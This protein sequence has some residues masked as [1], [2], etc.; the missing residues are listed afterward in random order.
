MT[1]LPLERRQ[2]TVVVP[3]GAALISGLKALWPVN[4]RSTG[5]AKAPPGGRVA[6]WMI[7]LVPLERCQTVV[8]VPSGAEAT[9]GLRAVRPVAERST[10]T[11]KAPPGGRVAAWMISLVP[12][13]RCHT[14]VVVPSGAEATWGLKAF[15]P[16]AERSTGAAKAPPGGRVAAWIISLVPLERRQTAVVVPSGAVVIWGSKAVW[17]P[18]ER[19]TG[20]PKAPPGGRVAAWMSPEGHSGGPLRLSGGR[21]NTGAGDRLNPKP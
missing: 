8:V 9:W 12:L 17:P 15:R 5:A 7:W 13:E 21:P 18:T 16:V 4:E 14:V 1:W 2:A 10:G 19:S 20:A 3:S 11:A 6:A